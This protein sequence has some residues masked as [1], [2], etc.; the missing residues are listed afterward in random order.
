MTHLS[1]TQAEE[2]LQQ[3]AE[4]FTQWRQNRTSVRGSRIPAPLWTEV[5]ALVEVLAVPRVAKALHLKPQA[6]KRRRGE[7]VAHPPSPPA[8]FVEVAP[9]PWR[10]CTADRKSVV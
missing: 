2:H 4:Q 6:L 8:P 9:S 3:V 10:S 7:T 5:L 1:P